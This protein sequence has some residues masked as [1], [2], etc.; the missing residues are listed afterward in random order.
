MT[1]DDNE[2]SLP[3]FQGLKQEEEEEEERQEEE[4]EEEALL[5]DEISPEVT[6]P[7][8]ESPMSEPPVSPKP[9]SSEHE[10]IDGLVDQDARMQDIT[11]LEPTEVPMDVVEEVS[12]PPTEERLAAQ[13][14]VDGTPDS[15]MQEP[16]E[17]PVLS[18][19]LGEA[20]SHHASASP[21]IAFE[22]VTDAKLDSAP[23]SPPGAPSEVHS[24]PHSQEVY[25]FQGVSID[26]QIPSSTVPEKVFSPAS[27][28]R[29][30][31][32]HPSTTQATCVP[33]A[34]A[35]VIY[36]ALSRQPSLVVL[37]ATFAP[38]SEPPPYNFSSVEADP[39][40]AAES[41]I[42]QRN[43]FE[44][45]YYYSLP[46][47]KSLPAEFQR[48]GKVLKQ[49]RKRE[50][51]RD[52][53][54]KLSDGRKDGKDDWVPLGA[55]RWGAII[56]ANPLWKRVSRA[57]KCL[58]TREWGVRMLYISSGTCSHNI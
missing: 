43:E 2:L 10:A 28:E 29:E 22:D 18:A 14:R 44:R 55:N 57:S 35:Q 41:S 49:Q 40:P 17:S 58:S 27:C 56:R 3:P 51:E 45:N 54:E 26:Q 39:S 46:P 23:S 34:L 50:K 31:I 9:I 13:E 1:L 33:R 25:Q 48:K 20:S 7:S 5:P 16:Q 36:P 4:E 21:P 38:I 11:H 37:K 24:P 15:S 52:K 53:G 6:E 8:R 47:L 32:Q 42:T 12:T 19:S 30:E